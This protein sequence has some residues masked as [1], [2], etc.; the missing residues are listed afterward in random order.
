VNWLELVGTGWNWLELVGTGWNWL[1]L[2]GTG[3]N[4]LEVGQLVQGGKH[5]IYFPLH[6]ICTQLLVNLLINI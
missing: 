3:W 2:V 1:E 5:D 4:W 6:K